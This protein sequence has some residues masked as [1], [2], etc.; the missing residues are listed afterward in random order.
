M[1]EKWNY[2]TSYF[3]LFFG[4]FV[5]ETISFIKKSFDKCT[6]STCKITNSIIFRTIFELDQIE[7]AQNGWII[8]KGFIK[9]S[10]WYE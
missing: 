3:F 1:K 9:V 7:E 10:K 4:C 8:L 6:T 5:Q 2:I